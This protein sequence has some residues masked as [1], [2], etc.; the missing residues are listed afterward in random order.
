MQGPCHVLL[1]PQ[2]QRAGPTHLL[3]SA[4]GQLGQWKRHCGGTKLRSSSTQFLSG[5]LC[6]FFMAKGLGTEMRQYKAFII[7]CEL[8]I[9]MVGEEKNIGSR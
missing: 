5:S 1:C 4:Q 2:E 6:I 8:Q 3:H 9:L 7:E